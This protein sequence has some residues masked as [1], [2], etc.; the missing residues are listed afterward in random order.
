MLI[1]L[2]VPLT[3]ELTKQKDPLLAGHV[4]THFDTMDKVFPLEY[5]LLRGVMFDVRAV[6]E[7]R[8]VDLCDIDLCALQAGMFAAFYTGRSD[9]APYGTPDYGKDHPQLSPALI[10]ALLDRGVAVIAVDCQGIRRGKEHTPAD[11]K[12]ADRGTFVVENLCGLGALLPH[13]DRFTACTFPLSCSGMSGVPC[14]V[15][16][17]TE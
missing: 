6:A 11:Q 16:A 13:K 4:G 17:K 15:M 7:T 1:D 10:D 8:D 5:A 14:R 2:S 3:P 9:T 12:C